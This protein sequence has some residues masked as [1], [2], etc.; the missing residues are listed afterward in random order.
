M[1]TK[2]Q[3]KTL[4]THATAS[5][6]EILSRPTSI[7]AT[8]ELTKRHQIQSQTHPVESNRQPLRQP[9]WSQPPRPHFLT[10]LWN[11][12][13][14]VTPRLVSNSRMW[15]RP[16]DVTFVPCSQRTRGL[17]LLLGLTLCK[18]SSQAGGDWG[19][20]NPHQQRSRVCSPL[21]HKE[22]SP[23]D[24]PVGLEAAPSPVSPARALARLTLTAAC[25]ILQ[26]KT[27]LSPRTLTT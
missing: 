23:S 9:W 1:Q 4:N 5:D 24:S 26:Q 8:K 7:S 22:R 11:L 15:G 10:S 21:G 6:Q 3:G 19:G 14:R 12:W 25:E 16:W 2:G 20:R 27:Q 13:T 18:A 17:R